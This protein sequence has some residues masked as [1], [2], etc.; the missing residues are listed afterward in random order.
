[1][2]RALLFCLQAAVDSCIVQG[3]LRQYRCISQG[4]LRI[5]REQFS[6]TRYCK[7]THTPVILPQ[8]K[9]SNGMK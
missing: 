1:V 6:L 5:L 4:A 7:V 3:L 9:S 8:L 2:L